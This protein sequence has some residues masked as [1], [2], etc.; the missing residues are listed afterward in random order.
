MTCK[1][2]AENS[3]LFISESKDDEEEEKKREKKSFL[4]LY[5]LML[6]WSNGTLQIYL[7]LQMVIK[8]YQ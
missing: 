4:F 3:S 1:E 2:I 8:L 7:S 6:I 5:Y